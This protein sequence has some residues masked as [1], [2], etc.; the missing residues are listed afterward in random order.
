MD[1]DGY[2]LTQ[3][4]RPL[5]ADDPPEVKQSLG[6]EE[7]V[8]RL[9]DAVDRLDDEAEQAASEEAL[10]SLVERV[11]SNGDE[12]AA[13]RDDVMK[14]LALVRQK[15]DTNRRRTVQNRVLGGGRKGKRL[16]TILNELEHRALED[17]EGTHQNANG[18]VSMRT[19]DIMELADVSQQT[20]SRYARELCEK[21][22]AVS[23][24]RPPWA[25]SD[26]S[27]GKRLRFNLDEFEQ[28]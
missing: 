9:R 4:N 5:T 18:K 19:D 11:E 25:T 24:R 12:I 20:A 26:A 8:A 14:E 3:R 17:A 6:V 28:E 15:V 21:I 23:W 16:G 10:A 2:T 27:V 7:E 22:G 13:L 1:E